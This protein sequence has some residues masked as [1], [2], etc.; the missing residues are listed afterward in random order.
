MMSKF[1]LQFLRPFRRKNRTWRYRHFVPDEEGEAK[2]KAY[3][4]DI[5]VL[6]RV[7]I[8]YFLQLVVLIQ[9]FFSINRVFFFSE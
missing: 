5:W 6:L 2:S 7:P 3:N 1:R 8:L 9:I 4:S